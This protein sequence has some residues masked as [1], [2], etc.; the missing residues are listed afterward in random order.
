MTARTTKRG[1][2]ERALGTAKDVADENVTMAANPTEKSLGDRTTVRT[3][4][5]E[6][7]RKRRRRNIGPV[8]DTE[9]AR[10]REL[11]FFIAFSFPHNNKHSKQI[12]QHLQMFLECDVVHD[13]FLGISS[14]IVK[15]TAHPHGCLPNQCS[16]DFRP[17]LDAPICPDWTTSPAAPLS[18]RSTPT[19]RTLSGTQKSS[20]RDAIQ[21]ESPRFS[22]RRRR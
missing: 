2:C 12:L 18:P 1:G 22:P 16:R 13:H 10:A 9:R 6:R 21:D 11:N 8:L 4:G 7:I 14:S 5:R 17:R 3:R 20:V 19:A 15:Y